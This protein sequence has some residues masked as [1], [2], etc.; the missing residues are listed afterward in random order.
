[1]NPNPPKFEDKDPITVACR[2]YNDNLQNYQS[3][4]T[5]DGYEVMNSKNP[6]FGPTN[7]EKM[8]NRNI[9]SK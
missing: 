6:F 7:P 8:I 4:G 1:L 3:D 9:Q 2:L 5:D